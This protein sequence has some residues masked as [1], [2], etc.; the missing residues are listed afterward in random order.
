MVVTATLPAS[1]VVRF[2]SDVAGGQ[3]RSFALPF[4]E[5]AVHKGK[6]RA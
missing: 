2:G 3:H 6:E 1:G 5:P 4:V